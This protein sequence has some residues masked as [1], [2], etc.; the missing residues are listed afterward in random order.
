MSVDSGTQ[1]TNGQKTSEITSQQ[2]GRG[3]LGIAL[4]EAAAR[5]R[6]RHAFHPFRG[7]IRQPRW[8]G[9]TST[10]EPDFRLDTRRG[11][12]DDFEDDKP[13]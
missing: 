1:Q 8:A 2:R 9:F 11:H 13:G 12:E 5:R 3:E 6:V 4:L 10:Q 7:A